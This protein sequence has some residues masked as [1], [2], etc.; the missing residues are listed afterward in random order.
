MEEI[1]ATIPK[2]VPAIVSFM[3]LT[4]CPRQ[5]NHHFQPDLLIT[6]ELVPSLFVESITQSLLKLVQPVF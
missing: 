3:A 4:V 5:M 6:Q 2:Y 1:G